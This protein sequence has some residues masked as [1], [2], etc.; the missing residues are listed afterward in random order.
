MFRTAP[1]AWTPTRTRNLVFHASLYLLAIGVALFWGLALPVLGGIFPFI[2]GLSLLFSLIVLVNYRFGV[3]L[4][5]LLL[6]ISVTNIFPHEI[7]GITG[8]NPYNL[9]FLVTLFSFLFHAAWRRTFVPYLGFPSIWWAY[10][11]PITVAALI[12]MNH[13]GEIPEIMFTSDAVKFTNASGYLRDVYIK[14]I[15][16]L[17]VTFLVGAAIRDRMR[18]EWVVTALTLSLLAFAGWVVVY[19]A[20]FNLGLN[21]LSDSGARAILT[22]TGLHANQ[23]GSMSAIGLLLCIFMLAE[24]PKGAIKILLWVTAVAAAILLV[25]SFSRGAMLTFLAGFAWFLFQQRKMS[26]LFIALLFAIATVPFLPDSVYERMSVGLDNS[27][28]TVMTDSNDALTAGRV[29]GVWLPQLPD[30]L[31]SPLIGR[32]LDSTLWSDALRNGSITILSANPHNLYLKTLL[33]TGI[34]GLLLFAL[35]Y[36]DLWRRFTRL[37]QA[38]DQPAIVHGLA[39]GSRAALLGFLAFGLSN[40]NFMPTPTTFFL[41]ISIGFLIGTAAKPH[42]KP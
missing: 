23:I 36:R 25:L 9:I 26:V 34:L 30:F 29:A 3:W 16:Y 8:L 42:N 15:T 2:L 22:G 27:A 40:G 41:F 5:V 18:P 21:I 11:A 35:F 7:L 33:N 28:G 24:N 32:G 39:K 1:A 38:E 13:V 14:P 12:G 31:A 19:I 20:Y 6:P 37:A 17:M 10:L 4:L